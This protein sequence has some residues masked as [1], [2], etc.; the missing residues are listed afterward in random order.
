MAI[1]RRRSTRSPHSL[2]R[3]P[4]GA[5]RMGSAT[6]RTDHRPRGSDPSTTPPGPWRVLGRPPS[7][8][9]VRLRDDQRPAAVVPG[10]TDVER[11]DRA[12]GSIGTRQR[13]PV[14][15]ASGPAPG[16]SAGP[17]R[18]AFSLPV[19][20]RGSIGRPPRS[21]SL[22][23]PG[24]A[25]PPCWGADGGLRRR[26]PA[27]RSAGSSAWRPVCAGGICSSSTWSGSWSRR[28]SRWRSASTGSAGPCSSRHS[29]WSWA[30]SS[31]S[32]RSRTPGSAS[33]AAAGATRAS[34]TSSG[35]S[36][37]WCSDRRS[38]WSS[39]TVRPLL[40][41]Q[42]VGRPGSRARSGRSSCS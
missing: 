10:R 6:G 13:A 5:R 24:P 26:V 28:T 21:E 17:R 29:R 18:A 36:L 34:P 4:R 38:A 12:E 40:G 19:C 39:S 11:A 27:L 14:G 22:L 33:T 23:P 1:W 9:I 8:P 35:S 2:P 41:G 20:T 7:P 30:S 25:L 42:H 3:K 31:R 15:L 37:R 32:A 16:G